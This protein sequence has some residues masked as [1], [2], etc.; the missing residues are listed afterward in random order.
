MAEEIVRYLR[1]V[2]RQHNL[3]AERRETETTL[4]AQFQSDIDRYQQLRA[5]NPRR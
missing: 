5:G 1:E 4:R 2:E 3:L